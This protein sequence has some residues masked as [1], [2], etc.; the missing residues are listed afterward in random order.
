MGEE[1]S[2]FRAPGGT[3]GTWV[4]SGIPM[5]II[6]WSVDTYDYTGKTP[7]QIFYVFRTRSAKGTLSFAMIPD[8][9]STNPFP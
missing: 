4:D 3:Y 2:L 8:N 7:K 6:Q 1:A 9:I 5:P